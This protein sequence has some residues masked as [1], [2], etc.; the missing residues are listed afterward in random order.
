MSLT[1]DIERRIG[2]FHLAVQ[3]HSPDGVMALLGPSGCGK[4]MTLR[5]IAG[6]DRPDRGHIELNG[7]VLY[8]SA[9]RVCLPPQRREV[10][11]LFQNYA[12]FPNMTVRGNVLTALHGRCARA[13]AKRRADAV[14]AALRLES[15]ANHRPSQLSGGQ[16]QRAALAR[17]LA[18]PPQLLMLDEPFAALDEALRQDIL[19]ELY[20]LLTRFGNDA[21][22][23]THNRE[24]A[25]R[26]SRR[27]AVMA[28]GRILERNDTRALFRRPTRLA[29]ARVLG[30]ENCSAARPLD[31][32]RVLAV[33]W[34]QVLTLSEVP[35]GMTHVGIRA[36]DLHPAAASDANRLPVRRVRLAQGLTATRLQMQLP[37]GAILQW[38]T[39]APADADALAVDP[40]DVLPL[41]ECESRR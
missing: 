22:L 32:R 28:D 40:A 7:R 10:G 3:L 35:P 21:I 31:A 25:F 29:A 9:A 2:D 27:T 1:I 38:Q 13:D 6:I 37:K 8:D 24:E 30:V 4:S 16:A 23:V 15:V 39:A 41:W 34:D 18:A 14:L 26:L 33:D 19:D 36:A 11:Y 17:I 5:C 20:E 12:L